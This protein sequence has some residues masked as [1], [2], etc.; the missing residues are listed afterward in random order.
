MLTHQTVEEILVARGYVTREQLES[1]YSSR[2]NASQPVSELLMRTGQISE[3]QLTECLAEEAG[4]P[5]YSTRGHHLDSAVCKILPHRF[6]QRYRA[7]VTDLTET[8]ATVAMANPNDLQAID[9]V[10][11]V[12]GREVDP[13]WIAESELLQAHR[14]IYG[15][16]NDVQEIILEASRD[17]ETTGIELNQGD[18]EEDSVS[19][20]ELR[21]SA[22]GSPIVQLANALFAQ[23]ISLSASDIHIEPNKRS[24]R[25][26][27]RID[28]VLNDLMELPKEVHRAV[29]SRIK[30][31]SGLDIAERRMPQDGRCSLT[32]AE[33]DFDFRVATYPTVH[34]EKICIRVLD[35]RRSTQEIDKL[36]LQKHHQAQ[37]LRAVEAPQGFVIVCGPTGSGKT[38]TLY[39]LLNHLNRPERHIITV[40]DPV[41]YQIEG[42][43]QA[44]VNRAAGVTFASGLRA[45]LRQDP[46]VILVG[47]SRDLE[48]ASTAIEAALT[49]HM[50]LTSLHANQAVGSIVRLVEMGVEPFMVAASVCCSVAQRL[51][52]LNCPNCSATYSPDQELLERMG[53]PLDAT[54]RI[55]TGCD[56][57][58]RTGYKGRLGIYEV[59]LIT[60]EI[61][62]MILEQRHSTEIFEEA[63]SQGFETMKSDARY[64]VL[65]GLTSPEEAARVI[66]FEDHR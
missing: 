8:A 13:V 57:C 23:A 64:K 11:E 31:V 35:K 18:G 45:M 46:D 34:G 62:R 28:G 51:V 10:A 12:I 21:E 17:L 37:V 41:E 29:V 14:E 38:T 60:P 39:S 30:I 55:G 36:G 47:E 58:S 26:R 2:K 53:L 56:T 50:V 16:F 61:Q 33:G 42:I 43:V 3:S 65:Q 20:V 6:A 40:E 22:E 4:V 49:G 54:Y 66:A 5:Y 1:A 24:V 19:V 27:F 48:T 25:V 44:N 52:R 15:V 63:A 32:A 7:L 9:S 59:L